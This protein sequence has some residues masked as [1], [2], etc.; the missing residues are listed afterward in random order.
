MLDTYLNILC[1]HID[2]NFS[3]RGKLHFTSLR[4]PQKYLI[5]R[6]ALSM[7]VDEAMSWRHYSRWLK[8]PVD[9]SRFAWQELSASCRT[10]NPIEHRSCL[11]DCR[12]HINISARYA[13][14]SNASPHSQ[15]ILSYMIGSICKFRRDVSC[16]ALRTRDL[17]RSRYITNWSQLWEE[18]QSVL[19]LSKNFKYTN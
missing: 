11:H 4:S 1:I 5:N 19:K 12:C 17:S 6:E 8:F 18:W 16:F 13:S 2:T 14:H 3:L 15:E 10:R 7:P 9:I